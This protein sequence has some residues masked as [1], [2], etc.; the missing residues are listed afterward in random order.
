MVTDGYKKV[1]LFFFYKTEII[2][3]TEIVHLSDFNGEAE[4][5]SKII[6]KNNINPYNLFFVLDNGYVT[7]KAEYLI[8]LFDFKSRE[9]LI[10]WKQ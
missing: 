8:S 1:I 5:I 2:C 7:Y 3:F 6:I 4:I 10:Q 9:D